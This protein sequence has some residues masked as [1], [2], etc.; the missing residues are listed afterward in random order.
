MK[1]KSLPTLITII[2]LI[3][4]TWACGASAPGSE[5]VGLQQIADHYSQTVPIELSAVAQ[6][7]TAYF[8]MDQKYKALLGKYPIL[9]QCPKSWGDAARGVMEGRYDNTNEEGQPTGVVNSQLAIDALMVTEDN[10][11]GLEKC[12]QLFQDYSNEVTA[13]RVSNIDQFTKLWDIEQDL[14]TMYYGEVGTALA[15]KLLDYVGAEFM[16]TDLALHFAPP[17]VWYPTFNLKFSIYDQDRCE[18][19]K[20][21]YPGQA[22][23]NPALSECQ[24]IGNAA[25]DVI[26]RPPFSREMRDTITTGEEDLQLPGQ[27]PTAIPTP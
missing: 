17:R 21:V 11:E 18:V 19:F 9:E 4:S 12:T 25:Y 27:N 3:L 20:E 24:L 8:N 15:V 1:I 14:A 16:K 22:Y 6:A 23:W 10:P 7:K 5:N 26:F 13:W 2:F